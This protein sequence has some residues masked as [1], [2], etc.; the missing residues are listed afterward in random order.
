MK[1]VYIYGD[2]LM[3]H[4]IKGQKW[5]IENGP[6]YP[7]TDHDKLSNTIF[8][9]AKRNEPQITKDVSNAVLSSGARMYGLEHK[10]K[11]KDSISRKIQTDSKEK[12]ISEYKAAEDIKDAVRYTSIANDNN[13]VKSYNQVKNS[14]EKKRIQRS[15][16]PKLFR[17]V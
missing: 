14:L 8:N 4:G 11:T 7:L 16:M 10:L 2:S 1:Q 9:N 12:Q 15:S 3:H 5:G 17:Y 6:P 13:F